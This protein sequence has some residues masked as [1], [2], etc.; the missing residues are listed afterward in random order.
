MSK[1]P[2]KKNSGSLLFFLLIDLP[3]MI[4]IVV[5]K[6]II[7]LGSL[8]YVIFIEIPMDIG[9]ASNKRERRN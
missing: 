1:K 4:I 3:V 8:F 9:K 2:S 7:V 5:L 6:G